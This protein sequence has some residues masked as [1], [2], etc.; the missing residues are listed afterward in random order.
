MRRPRPA[1]SPAPTRS[2]RAARCRRPGWARCRSPM[3]SRRR[4]LPY[5]TRAQQLGAPRRDASAATAASP[6]ICSA[7]RREAQADYRAALSGA[8]GDEAR[9]RLALSLAISG[10]RPARSQTLAP[11]SAKGDRGRGPGPRLR[12]CADRR[13]QRRDG[14]DQRGDAGQLVARRA[15]PAASAGASRRAEGRG[16]Q[17]RHLPG[18][19]R[20]GLRLCAPPTALRRR[21]RQRDHGPACRNRRAAARASARSRPQPAVQP[22]DVQ[23]AAA[24]SQVAYVRAGP[25][26]RLRARRAARSGCS[27]RAAR[28]ADALPSQFQRMKSQEPRPV[29][30][31]HA[32]MSRSSPDR[33]RLVIGPFRGTSDAEIFA[34]DLQI[35]RHQRLQLD[36]FPSRQD[37]ATRHGMK[38]PPASPRSPHRSRGRLHPEAE[39]RPARPARHLPARPRPASSIRSPSAASATRRRC[40]SRPTATI[41]GSA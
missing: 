5:F 2:I 6:T 13:F 15:V 4:A 41:S 7:S 24:P 9:R 19:R 31:H 37:C 29:R 36:Q 27:L 12:P 38:L 14:R 39:S 1:S 30:R 25:A 34:E 20:A 33:A 21:P 28:D 17:P 26:Q 10:D 3:A 22:H 32:A 8:D 18:L 11:L 35:G 16:G 23:A 40:S